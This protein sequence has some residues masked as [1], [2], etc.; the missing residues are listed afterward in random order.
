M[1]E[2]SITFSFLAGVISFLSPCVL[3]IIPGFLAYLAGSS[4]QGTE[5]K[6]KSIFLNS[7]FFVLGF[8]LVFSILGVLLNSLLSDVAYSTQTWISRIGGVIII[9][10]GFYL[11]GLIKIAFLEREYRFAVK[12]KFSSRY[13][14]SFLFVLPLDEWHAR[15]CSPTYAS[16]SVIFSR[17]ILLPTFRTRYL[18][19]K[20]RATTRV[21]RLKKL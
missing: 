21:L 6:R 11:M 4:L 15:S 14:T 13:I 10:F 5:V 12:A 16:T 2:L 18:P 9:F 7:F 20:S 1:D 19:S 17:I 8:S 3:P